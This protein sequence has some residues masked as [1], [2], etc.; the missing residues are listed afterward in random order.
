VKH[1]NLKAVWTTVL[2]LPTV[3]FY[4]VSPFTFR[5]QRIWGDEFLYLDVALSNQTGVNVFTHFIPGLMPLT[6]RPYLVEGWYALSAFITGTEYNRDEFREVNGWV[7]QLVGVPEYF[8][9]SA[10]VN[11]LLAFGVAYALYVLCRRLHTGHWIALIATL[12]FLVS[13]RVW[14]YTT[15]LWAELPHMAMVFGAVLLLI[16]PDKLERR[17]WLR[18]AGAGLL[19]G[20]AANFKGIAEL[21]M[22]ASLLWLTAATMLSAFIAYLAQ[23]ARQIGERVTASLFGCSAQARLRVGLIVVLAVSF[24]LPV[25]AQKLGTLVRYGEWTISANSCR[26]VEIGLLPEQ[27]RSVYGR[28]ARELMDRERACDLRVSEY[29]D[30]VDRSELLTRQGTQFWDQQIMNSFFKM[31]LD[32]NRWTGMDV[33]EKLEW[34]GPVSS[35]VALVMGLYGAAMGMFFRRS[36]LLS[37]FFWFYLMGLLVIGWNPRFFIQLYPVA[38]VLGAYGVANTHNLLREA[39]VFLPSLRRWAS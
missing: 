23:P 36:V 35:I 21:W 28:A 2:T 18:Y 8:L 24:A 12:L 3:L 20:Y 7:A 33:L 1:F 17:A 11:V 4:L 38:L 29:L 22:N 6:H 37:C 39:A 30:S 15:A 5:T 26:N 9:A 34:L 10:I 32:R 31:G 14:F 16:Y 27:P 13:P 25:G 19:L